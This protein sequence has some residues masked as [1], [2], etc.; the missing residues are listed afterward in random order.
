M[1][2]TKWNAQPIKNN[3]GTEEEIKLPD[4]GKIFWHIEWHSRKIGVR[5]NE[6]F[7]DK[8]ARFRRNLLIKC[9]TKEKLLNIN[10]ELTSRQV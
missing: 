10:M 8:M 7:N 4:F 3:K 9:A 5:V 6:I 2:F 1:A